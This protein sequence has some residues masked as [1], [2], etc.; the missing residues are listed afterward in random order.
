MTNHQ[1]GFY[2]HRDCDTIYCATD[3]SLWIVASQDLAGMDDRQPEQIDELP[4][5][6]EPVDLALVDEAVVGI[7]D[8]I[9]A[10]RGHCADCDGPCQGHEVVT[11]EAQI[12]VGQ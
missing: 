11:A 3:G 2:C 4:E 8:E 12:E 1:P 9:E 10:E 5:G 7:A 6:A